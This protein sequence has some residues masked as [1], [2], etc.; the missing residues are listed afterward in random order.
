VA[1]DSICVLRTAIHHPACE[2]RSAPEATVDASI[3][4]AV[5]RGWAAIHAVRTQ[6]VI[7]FNGDQYDGRDARLEPTQM[8]GTLTGCGDRP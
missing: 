8:N 3:R 6:V 5:T 4:A 1:C 2:T 7:L